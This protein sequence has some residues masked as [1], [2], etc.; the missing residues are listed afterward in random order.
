MTTA[1]LWEINHPFYA[2]QG[3]YF[4]NECHIEY[5]SWAE[6]LEFEGGNDLDL[7]L[8]YRWDWT[9]PDPDDYEPD[10]ALPPETLDLFY[11]GQRKAILRSVSVII[12]REDEPAVRQWLTVRAEHMRRVWEPLLEEEVMPQ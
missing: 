9:V 12:R 4:S 11:V 2:A 1:H 8:V 7:N 5:V 10:E 3:N 6:F